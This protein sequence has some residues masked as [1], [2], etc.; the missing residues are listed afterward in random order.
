M[1]QP[2]PHLMMQNCQFW[3]TKCQEGSSVFTTVAHSCAARLFSNLWPH[4]DPCLVA[5]EVRVSQSVV[6]KQ[7]TLQADRTMHNTIEI[8]SE[9]ACLQPV[10]VK[11]V[12]CA[13]LDA[14]SRSARVSAQLQTGPFVH[15]YMWKAATLASCS[16]WQ[17][18][19][20]KGSCV[21]CQQW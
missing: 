9:P 3:L 21:S 15:A 17:A 11:S 12:I 7:Q 6:H 14:A 2:E 16:L 5:V 19:P 18:V 20:R 8:M 4:N 13:H 10:I 1:L